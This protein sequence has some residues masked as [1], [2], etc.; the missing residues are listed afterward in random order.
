MTNKDCI[1][2]EWSPRFER[3]FKKLPKEIKLLYGD[4]IVQFEDDWRH[5]SLRV[6]RIVGTDDIWEA[7]INMSRRFTFKWIN[8]ELGNKICQLRNIGDHDHC[9]RPPY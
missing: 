4:K 9:L 6:K 8:D 3:A 7:S 1:I 5:P 2:F